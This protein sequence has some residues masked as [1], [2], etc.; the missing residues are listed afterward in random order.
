M[1]WLIWLKLTKKIILSS[2][3]LWVVFNSDGKEYT[4]ALK[5]YF[6]PIRVEQL[7]EMIQHEDT[8]EG[9]REVWRN[10]SHEHY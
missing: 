3:N 5:G 2:W 4:S 7:K 8:V 9:C 6:D 1:K 10:W